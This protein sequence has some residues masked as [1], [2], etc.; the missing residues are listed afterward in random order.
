MGKL[1]MRNKDQILLE[2]I[3]DKILILEKGSPVLFHYTGISNATNMMNTGKINLTYMVGSDRTN[4]SKGKAY[5]FSMSR[6]RHGGFKHGSPFDAVIF[7]FDGT[8]LGSKYQIRPFDYWGYSWDL[9]MTSAIADEQEDRLFSHENE[10]PLYPYLKSV[11]VYIKPTD[12]KSY[13]EDNF[14]RAKFIKKKSEEN[15]IPCFVYNDLNA[16]RTNNRKK[17]ID[18]ESIDDISD[19][20]NNSGYDYTEDYANNID[21]IINVIT[22]PFNKKQDENV[23]KFLSRYMGFDWKQSV[24]SQLHNAKS[25]QNQKVR[26]SLYE[27]SRIERKN[28][29]SVL[30]ILDQTYDIIRVHRHLEQLKESLNMFIYSI[31]GEKHSGGIKKEYLKSYLDRYTDKFEEKVAG[32]DFVNIL[33]KAISVLPEGDGDYSPTLNYMRMA[34]D[35]LEKMNTEERSYMVAQQGNIYS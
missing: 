35:Y 14:K 11:N 1:I 3:Y 17:S 27:L 19:I 26:K 28:K 30:D 4:M 33:K 24:G 9:Q 13:N 29:K 5:Y 22:D 20:E 7:E 12:D 34:K 6:I 10:I 31:T 15:N 21:T 32:I 2:N 8:K 18:M 16:W 23:K 25:S